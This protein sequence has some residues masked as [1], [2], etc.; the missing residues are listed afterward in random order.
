MDCGELGE[1]V[2]KNY[3]GY[4]QIYTDE[5]K[6]A[7]GVG[8]AAVRKQKCWKATLPGMASIYAAELYAIQ[9]ALEIID[10]HQY[11]RSLVCSDSLNS[12]VA[13][14]NSTNK[15]PLVQRVQQKLHR[16]E[17]DGIQVTFL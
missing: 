4:R 3:A 6:T 5:S 17:E 1:V 13:I 9:L 10:A 16:L 14:K 7:Q 8:A 2:E 11:T 15:N 12:L